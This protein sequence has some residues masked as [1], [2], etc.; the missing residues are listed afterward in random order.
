MKRIVLLALMAGFTLT[1][2]AQTTLSVDELLAASKTRALTV[3]ETKA[4]I[5]G[6]KRDTDTFIYGEA[7]CPTK[8]EAA[9]LAKQILISNIQEWVASQENTS[10]EQMV[11]RE[12]ATAS[13]E[14]NLMR[15][16]M[17]RSFSYM[18]KS[19]I[20]S[21]ATG[22]VTAEPTPEPAP[23]VVATVPVEEP[24]PVE[25]AA[26][27][28][29]EVAAAEELAI[30]PEAM[31]TIQAA[32]QAQAVEAAPVV[33]AV[34][35]APAAAVETAAVATATATVAAVEA[36]PVVE[37]AP[38]VEPAPA[39]VVEPAPVVAP[40]PVEEAP[41]PAPAT[42]FPIET[43]TRL[44]T[45][46]ELDTLCKQ[47]EDCCVHGKVGRDMDFDMVKQAYLVVYNRAGEIK[48]VLDKMEM[49]KKRINL[50][51]KQEDST[52]NYPGHGAKWVVVTK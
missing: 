50:K 5:N 38:I 49:G 36:A 40:A 37:P 30:S 31:E 39:P 44:S 35:S 43:L 52:V 4:L 27:E 24:A 29:A 32:Q 41:A 3:D 11:V 6:I 8:E 1:L 34:E 12:V 28:V 15:G 33:A 26:T 19:D 14:M 23:E 13:H 17:H 48:A 51:T 18:R 9:D 2:N 16:M 45:I 42:I 7:T 22:T 47:Y 20:I 21:P 10:T 46:Q 25:V